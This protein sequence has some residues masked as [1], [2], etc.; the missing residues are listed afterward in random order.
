MIEISDH[1]VDKKFYMAE[2]IENG[3]VENLWI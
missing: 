3:T 2:E 1:Q